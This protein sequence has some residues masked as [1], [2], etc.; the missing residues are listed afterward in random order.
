LRTTENRFYREP[1]A[2]HPVDGARVAA[3][4][5]QLLTSVHAELAQQPPSRENVF[6][7]LNALAISTAIVLAGTED[8][9]EAQRFFHDALV[10]QVADLKRQA[11]DKT[12]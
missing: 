2:P 11:G 6:V 10:A 4:S 12:Q 9:L 8:S 1:A 5:E 7:A 3:L